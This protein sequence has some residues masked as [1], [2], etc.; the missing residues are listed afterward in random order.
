MALKAICD[1][2]ACTGCGTCRQICSRNAISMRPDK[3]GFLFPYI[4]GKKCIE[5]GLCVRSCPTQRNIKRYHSAFYM[6]WHNDK[7]ILLSSSSGGAFSAIANVALNKNGVVFGAVRDTDSS[8]VIHK[9]AFSM[10]EIRMQRLSKYYQSDVLETYSEAEKYLKAGRWVVYSGT[11]CQIAGL[12][13]FL[14]NKEYDRLVTV[15]ILCH[16]V[17]SKKIVDTYIKSMERKFKKKIVNI[18]FRTKAAKEGWQKG[19]GTRMKLEFIDDTS[20]IAEK[21]YDTFFL[22]FNKNLFLR[23]SCYRCKYCGTER[24]ADFTIGDFWGCN[25]EEVTPEQLRNG[26][27]LILVNSDKG[28]ELLAEIEKEMTIIEIRPEEAI[29]YNRALVQPNIRPKIRNYFFIMV[30]ILGYD[31][32]IKLIFC[33]KFIKRKINNIWRMYKGKG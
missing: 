13:S 1:H 12:Y 4:D 17:A 9:A 7:E 11:A 14:G 15:D 28:N 30:S 31:I 8:D 33:K 20:Y 29:P 19:G 5:C 10:Q 6:G 18:F 25:R 27:S 2:A 23:E 32:S 21:G 22:G 24:I 3:E 16:G 26:V